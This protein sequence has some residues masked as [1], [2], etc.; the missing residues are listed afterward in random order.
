MDFI[1]RPGWWLKAE[2][3]KAETFPVFLSPWIYL[4]FPK[5]SVSVG[6]GVWKDPHFFVEKVN[7]GMDFGTGN[8]R[9]CHV[10]WVESLHGCHDVMQKPNW[11]GWSILSPHGTESGP[12]PA[13]TLH[14]LGYAGMSSLDCWE[15]RL[16][17]GRS[18]SFL[19]LT[20]PTIQPEIPAPL[21]CLHLFLP[22]PLPKNAISQ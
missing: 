15:Q 8:S 13:P 3:L 11:V 18:F 16:E 4:V 21:P 10:C 7:E 14:P 2:R 5:I 17:T 22:F 19:P 20:F 9:W 6:I 12:G 1:N